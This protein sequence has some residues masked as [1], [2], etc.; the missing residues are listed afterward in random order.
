MKPVP[1]DKSSHLSPGEW[2]TDQFLKIAWSRGIQQQFSE[3]YL[4]GRQ[5]EI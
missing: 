4:F 3:E 2:P 1:Y 5:F